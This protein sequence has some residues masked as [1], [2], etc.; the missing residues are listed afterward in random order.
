MKQIKDDIL[1]Y[2]GMCDA[3]GKQTLQRGMNYRLNPTYSVMLMSQRSNAPYKDKIYDDGVTIEYEGH[4]VS[5]QSYTHN[6]KDED[7]PVKLPSGN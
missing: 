3:E 7:Q 1:S 5:K 4:N 2:R 6:P